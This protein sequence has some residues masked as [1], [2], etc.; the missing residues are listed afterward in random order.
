MAATTFTNGI[1]KMKSALKDS[2]Y[3]AEVSTLHI[4]PRKQP[5]DEHQHDE[6]DRPPSSLRRL[7]SRFLNRFTPA[8]H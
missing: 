6:D 8:K 3:T 1:S 4:V 5:S 2:Y 7:L